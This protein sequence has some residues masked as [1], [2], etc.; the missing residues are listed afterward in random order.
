[1][2]DDFDLDELINSHSKSGGNKSSEPKEVDDDE[3][4]LNSLTNSRNLD[5][6]DIDLSD[7]L[8]FGGDI[9]FDSDETDDLLADVF[10][11]EKKSVSTRKSSLSVNEFAQNV[12]HEIDKR[13]LPATPENYKIYF[14]EFLLRESDQFQEEVGSL[15][16]KESVGKEEDKSREIEETLQKSLKL[17]QQLL[18]ITT[19]VHGNISIMKNI[20]HKREEELLTRSSGDIIKLLRFDLSKLETV[21]QRQSTSMKGVYG[22]AVETVNSLQDKTIL[23]KDLGVYNRK[24]FLESL[25]LEIEK[26]EYFKYS[27]S[28]A[29][30]IPNRKLTA[31]NLTQRVA[32]AILKT[33]AK[34]LMEFFKKSDVVSYYGNNIFA[35]LMTHSTKEDSAEKI[36]RLSW[37]LKK[38]ALFIGGREIELQVK[39]GIAELL[40]DRKID[41]SLLKALDALKVANRSKD[42]FY[43][44]AKS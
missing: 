32:E 33:I 5:I 35:I 41:K 18:A 19:K 44:I 30:L 42:K 11:D 39:S 6:G 37:A 17:T 7:D 20:A 1:M 25:K 15:L 31:K 23:N 8:N 34:I 29:L 26:M 4:D 38:S 36:E 9:S 13:D 22:R 40:P 2:E 27:S 3:V 28:V 24:Y 14:T 16:E 10:D 43:E 21:L 12:I